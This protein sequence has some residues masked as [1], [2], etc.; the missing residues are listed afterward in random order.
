M[1]S[2]TAEQQKRR[3]AMGEAR[4]I[5]ERVAAH[6]DTISYTDLVDEGMTTKYAVNG[7][8]L[9]DLVRHFEA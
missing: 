5:L 7:R 2:L 1:A 4:Q 9:T 3:H 8:P 6:K